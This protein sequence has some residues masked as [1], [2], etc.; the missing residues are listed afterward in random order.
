MSAEPEARRSPPIQLLNFGCGRVYHPEWI[1]LDTAP[2]SSEVI[3]HDVRRAFPYPADS[4]D[5]LYGSH[6]LEHLQPQAGMRLLRECFRILKPGGIVRIAVPDLEVIARLYLQS[7]EGALA[8]DDDAAMRYD[9]IMLELYDQT[10]RTGPGGAMAAHLRDRMNARMAQF[11]V[12]RIGEEALVREGVRTT[13]QRASVRLLRQGQS[14]VAALRRAFAAACAFLFMG[15]E[16][17]AALREGI[18]RR[19]GEVHNWMYDRYSLARSLAHAGF[20]GARSRAANDSDIPDFAR[21]GLETADGR[22]RKPDS[23]YVEARKPRSN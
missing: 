16:G 18:F 12:A 17:S 7:L 19:S 4:F 1:N 14:G 21:Y 5:G 15:P 23:L 6:V 8:G 13:R 11:I 9:W 3:A 22:P 10:V 20:A 2:D